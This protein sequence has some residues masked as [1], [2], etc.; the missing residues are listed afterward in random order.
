[1]KQFFPNSILSFLLVLLSSFLLTVSLSFVADIVDMSV[2]PDMILFVFALIFVLIVLV[3]NIRN[4]IPLVHYYSINLKG[5]WLAVLIVV[6]FSLFIDIPLTYKISGIFS[7]FIDN[8]SSVMNISQ[9]LS[10]IILGPILEEI[11]FRGIFLRGLLVRYSSVKAILISSICFA[12]IH[13]NPCQIFSALVFGLFFGYIFYKTRSLLYTAVL[14]CIANTIIIFY[15]YHS[16]LDNLNGITII[17]LVIVAVLLLWH[18]CRMWY[19]RFL[20]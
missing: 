18:L 7:L 15:S 3:I 14:H 9:I 4:K 10:V 13:I 2:E 19:R 11:L 12:I 17:S 8:S 1:M 6:I 16:F 5:F 20:V